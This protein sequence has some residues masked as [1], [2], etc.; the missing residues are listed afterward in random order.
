M[1]SKVGL[2]L[3]HGRE[4]AEQRLAAIDRVEQL[5]AQGRSRLTAQRMVEIERGRAEAGRARRHPLSRQ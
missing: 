2:V 4:A 3:L 1:D 5:V